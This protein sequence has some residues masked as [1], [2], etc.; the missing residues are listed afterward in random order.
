[1]YKTQTDLILSNIGKHITL[2]QPEIKFFLSLLKFK[3]LKKKDFLLR[4]GEPCTTFNYITSGALRAFYRDVNDK[5]A[6]IMFAVTD[7]WITDMP[8]FI[9]QKPAMIHIEAIA[10]SRVLQLTKDDIDSLCIELPKFERFFRILMQNAYIREQLRVLQNLSQP[11]EV[12]YN[13]FLEK[14]PAIAKQVTLKNIASYLGITPEFLSVIRN[15]LRKGKFL[16]LP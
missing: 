14:Y 8:C 4:A 13:N 16:N 11:A 9:S 12:R 6:T 5:E 3:E 2:N 1:M 15:K 10:K 7:W